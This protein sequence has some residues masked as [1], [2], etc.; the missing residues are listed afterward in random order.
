M[1]LQ[2]YMALCEVA[3]RR[4][5]EAQIKCGCVKVNDEL[6]TEMGHIVDPD[7]DIVKVDDVVI[8]VCEKKHYY[9]FNKPG[10]VIVSAYDEKNRKL[11]LEYFS[12]IDARLFTVGRLDYDSSGIIFVTNDGEFANRVTHP[13]YECTKTYE[14]YVKGHITSKDIAK[15]RKGV[16]IDE[17]QTSPAKIVMQRVDANTHFLQITIREGR[18]RQVRKMIETIGASVD[19]LEREAIG[20]V[21]LGTLDF[22]EYRDLTQSEI[23][24]FF[25]LEPT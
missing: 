25:S 11:A 17:Y 9:A 12:S 2:K 4:K 22:G 16:I 1:R 8:N 18:N 15:L 23:D 14:V 20:N 24:Y 13:K 21:H 10:K 7:K 6:I 3:S 19:S 5:C